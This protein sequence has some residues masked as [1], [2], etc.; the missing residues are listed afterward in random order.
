MRNP[1]I[2]ALVAIAMLFVMP[3]GAN[4]DSP[5]DNTRSQAVAAGWTMAGANPQRTSWTPEE[6][7]GA[8]SPLWYKKFEAYIP[9]RV[10]IIAD[11]NTLYISTA[12]GLYAL[13]ATTGA[14]RWVYPTEM[15]LGH[16]PTIAAGVAYVGGLDHKLHAIDANTGQGLWTFEADAGF[17]TNP[18]V[19]GD[20]VFLGN[21]D[22]Y[23]YAVYAQGSPQAGTL[24]WKFKTGG[25][26]LYSAAYNNGTI[27]FA[28]NDSYAY[29]LN[30]NTGGLVWKSAKLPGAGFTSWWPVVYR[31]RVI[32]A[33]SN[34]Y[35]TSISPG[36][37]TQ[38]TE[39]ELSDVY[40]NHKN[41]PRGTYVGQTGQAPGDWA[42]G[43]TTIDTST[44]SGTTVPI[45]EYFEQKPYRRTVFVLDA[46][47]GAEISYDFDGDGKKEYAP[48]LWVGTHSGTRYPPVVGGDDV[49]YQSNNYM[50]DAYIA[51][52]N[53]SGWKMDTPFISIP[54][55]GWNAVDEPQAYSAGGNII[56][57]Q[58]CCDRLAQA[59]D[60]SQPGTTWS[61]FT[62]DLD[63]K[64]PGY[65]SMYWNPDANPPRNEY[66]T[67]Y[68][69]FGGRNGVYGFHADTNP[70]IPYNGKVYLHRSNAVIAFDD[71]KSTPTELP[72]AQIVTPPSAN[73]SLKTTDA[74]AA[75]LEAEVQKIVDAGH[76]RPAYISHGIF[77]F[78]AK[79]TC[80]DD[81]AS[82]FHNSSETLLTL[83]NAFPYLSAGLQTQVKTYLENE[84]ATY[85]PYTYNYI[86]WA[87]AAREVF[88]LPDDVQATIGGFGPQQENYTF[89]NN[90]GWGRN[91]FMFY[92]LWKYADTFGDAKTLFDAAKNRLESPPA[93]AELLK[94]PFEHNAFIAGYQ[95]YLGLEK[96]AGY[97]ETTAMRN[98]LNHLLALR[99]ANFT[100]DS[101]Y[102]DAGSGNR[103]A[104]CRTLNVA[105][106]FMFLTPE[107][108][109]YLRAN[110]A[111]KVQ[112]AVSEYERVAPFWF[113]TFS[114]TGFAENSISPLYDS[115]GIF[116]A[117]ALILQEPAST[118]KKYLDI[119]GFY[120]GDL[121]HLQKIMAVLERELGAPQATTFFMEVSPAQ[122]VVDAGGTAQYTITL[123][124]L[125]GFNAPVTLSLA[126][127]PAG[128]SAS[129]S[130]N[131]L[132]PPGSATLTVTDLQG[133][134]SFQLQI[135]ADGG[136]VSKF[137]P[138]GFS[139]AAQ[140]IYLP[141]VMRGQ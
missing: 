45:T 25:P 68:A 99:A 26:I 27:Y 4:A 67:P 49:L 73:F 41:E 117:K 58:R 59:M 21:R 39:L 140:K 114:E 113:V 110:A 36:A 102:G 135:N 31:N 32:F 57:W 94:R 78:R 20:K 131:S 100:A 120:R 40:P 109:D 1:F 121:Y 3:S 111:G 77:D 124:P 132:T 95:G 87:G 43:T 47:S 133:N 19:V 118:L 24:A 101:A 42:A 97:P 103:E 44:S 127:Q 66:T 72:T 75:E 7:P 90:N 14:E 30:E 107:L 84:L 98:T 116:I 123:T 16:S 89:K 56:Y 83:T 28:S 70:P 122:Q 138:V 61:Y 53:I 38:I 137:A 108:A 2:F 29:A 92:A 9:P 17:E 71:S 6:I 55:P 46:A 129:F 115:Y 52:G 119:P 37:A 82:Y 128:L 50:S 104:Y 48:I 125:G 69:V 5:A 63:S 33:G 11:N 60:V 136:G 80:G 79:D 81:F 106:N 91:P 105:S 141:L 22:G 65:N 35:R 18:L 51:G 23:F 88:D 13:D 76:L 130:T 12:N 74:L 112:A 139:V 8:L 62:Y 134:G 85:P 86:G 54:N 96:L 10:Q 93:D 64:L 34:N 126:A 15:P